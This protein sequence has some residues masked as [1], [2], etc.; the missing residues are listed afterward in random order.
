MHKNIPVA[1]IEI[2]ES[3]VAIVGIGE[4]HDIARDVDALKGIDLEIAEIFSQSAVINKQRQNAI[5]SEI[6]KRA[7]NVARNRG[8]LLFKACDLRR[9]IRFHVHSN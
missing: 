3:D 1:D 7:G 6:L 9:T 2:N 8:V 5:I 4:L